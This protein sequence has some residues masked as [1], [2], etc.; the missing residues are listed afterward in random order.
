MAQGSL[1]RGAEV[2]RWI[3][4]MTYSRTVTK[5]AM[6]LNLILPTAWVYGAEIAHGVIEASARMPHWTLHLQ[7][8]GSMQQ[9]GLSHW[10]ASNPGDAAI[11]L[12]RFRGCAQLV[13]ARC[14]VRVAVCDV[15]FHEMTR[16]GINDDAVGFAAGEHLRGH[17]FHHFAYIRNT[18]GWSAARERGFTR[19]CGKVPGCL[20]HRADTNRKDRWPA[21]LPTPVDLFFRQ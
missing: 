3:E 11:V 2:R 16:V 20:P 1:L 6:R 9:R 10:L 21:S 19:G 7:R 12:P 18:E 4:R 14:P 8:D 5:G 15:D 17:G 13:A